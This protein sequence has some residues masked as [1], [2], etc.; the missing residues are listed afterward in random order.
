MVEMAAVGA[1]EV[2]RLKQEIIRLTQVDVQM[3][4]EAIID[5]WGVLKMVLT[6]CFFQEL[7]Q[8][9]SDKIQSAQYG[10]VLL[11]EKEGLE[12]RCQVPW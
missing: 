1:E 11:E 4:M 10:L 5:D 9:S 7:D 6:R 3:K 12:A 8:T 2:E